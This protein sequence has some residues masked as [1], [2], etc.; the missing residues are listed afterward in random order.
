VA[1]RSRLHRAAARS[2]LA[3]PLA[4]ALALAAGCGRERPAAAPAAAVPPPVRVAI[5]A[6][7][8]ETSPAA[9]ELF[10]T[11][12]AV[13]RATLAA[14]IAGQVEAVPAT[15]GRRVAAGEL[16][17]RLA[18]PELAA[19]AAQARAQQA[20][21]ERELARERG[22]LASGAGTADLVK[23]LEDR[24]AQTRAAV[25]EAETLLDY[26]VVRAPVA[27]TIARDL[28]KPGDF[29]APGTPL[30]LL[31]GSDALEVEAAIPESL[32]RALA[33]GGTLPVVLGDGAA[34]VRAPIRELAA[35]SDS[36]ART[37]TARLDLPAGAAAH[38]GEFVRVGVPGAPASVLLVPRTA[39]S[40]MGQME[41]VIVVTPENRAALRLV[42]T[43]ALRGDLIEIAAGLEADERVVAAPPA[44]LREGQSLELA[45]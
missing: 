25:A 23:S 2:G 15:L 14:R 16:L 35:A 45:P 9:I 31:D 41:R 11:V 44:A 30:L 6:V 18:A 24:L 33:P 4:L 39:V 21:V 36:V 38:V 34:P 20:Q 28:V 1:C 22:L 3:F 17:V 19:R 7:R 10:G 5:A 27:G 13:Q 29:A 43:G 42:K 26:T 40:V 37:V 8:A 12:R 32:A